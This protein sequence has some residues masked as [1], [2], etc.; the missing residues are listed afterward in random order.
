MTTSPR[1]DHLAMGTA[2]RVLRGRQR[3]S[4]ERLSDH[5]G[6]HRNHIGMIERG[7]TSPG[8]RTLVRIADGLGIGLGELAAEF[9]VQ[10]RRAGADAG[11]DR[12]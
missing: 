5:A 1:P 7:E 2:I 10:R 3:L 9:D 12:G 8:L 4:Q 6:L 11:A